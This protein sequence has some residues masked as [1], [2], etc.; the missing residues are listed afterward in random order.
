VVAPMHGTV[1]EVLVGEG[2]RVTAGSAV[3]ILETMKMETS[4]AA[5]ISGT[6]EAVKVQAGDV[7]EAGEVVA[8]IG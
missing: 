3:A 2:D 5:T 7:V 6:I 8:V 4:V 1:L